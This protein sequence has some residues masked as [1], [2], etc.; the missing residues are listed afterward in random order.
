MQG[1]G[2]PLY[3][4]SDCQ[5]ASLFNKLLVQGKLLICTYSFNFIFGGASMQQVV[6]L[7]YYSRLTTR[8]ANGIA[9]RFGA[10]AKIR[11]GEIANYCQAQQVAL[12]SSRGPDIKDFNFNQADILNNVLAPGYLIWGAWTLLESITQIT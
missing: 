1:Q 10:Q 12:F 9:V 5:L 11:G 6:L 8:D 7:D 2:N 3:T 4:L